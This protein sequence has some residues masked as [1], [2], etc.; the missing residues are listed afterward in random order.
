MSWEEQLNDVDNIKLIY[1]RTAENV[2]VAEV[3]ERQRLLAKRL[4]CE[5]VYDSVS[6]YAKRY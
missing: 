1:G 3:T 5:G 2:R 6:E 4:R